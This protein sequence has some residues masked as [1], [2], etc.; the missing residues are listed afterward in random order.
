MPH[1]L[2]RATWVTIGLALLGTSTQAQNLWPM[3]GAT[4]APTRLT[5]LADQ[6]LTLVNAVGLD[7]NLVGL[8]KS[9]AH[10]GRLVLEDESRHRAR[11]ATTT[12]LEAAVDL[13]ARLAPQLATTA[14]SAVNTAAQFGG[15]L[16]A[17]TPVTSL[18]AIG[19]PLFGLPLPPAKSH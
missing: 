19:M 1:L 17:L 13:Q 15:T 9:A 3:P 2:H 18:G 8:L 14:V 10:N 4:P 16:M 6:E 5:A 11:E 12:A 7:A